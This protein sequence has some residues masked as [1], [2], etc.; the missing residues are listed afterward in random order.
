MRATGVGVVALGVGMWAGLGPAPARAEEPVASSLSGVAEVR[1]EEAAP[2]FPA[3]VRSL[4]VVR[5]AWAQLKP[6]LW[7]RRIGQIAKG[8]RIAWKAATDRL[9]K[10]PEG[11]CPRWIAVDPKGWICET[12]VEPSELEP[13]ATHLPV[14][15]DGYL[16]PER[17][18][19]VLPTPENPSRGGR[20]SNFEGIWAEGDTGLA[21]P[22]AWAQGRG[23]RGRI[24]PVPVRAAP[25]PDAEVV[26]ALTQ[27]TIVTPT[28]YSADKRFARV[29]E[30]AWVAV[31]DLHI[32][33]WTAPPPEVKP[34]E[35]WI[36]VDLDQQVLVA[37]EGTRPIAATL[38][39]SGLPN[40]QTP[41][42][43]FR[44]KWKHAVTRMAGT[45]YR[46]QVPWT[47]YYADMYALH[48]AYW[49]DRFGQHT[50]HGC[51]NVAPRD[52]R[53]LFAW[54]DPVLPPGWTVTYGVDEDPGSLVRVR[55]TKGRTPPLDAAALS[56]S[57]RAP[58][59][60]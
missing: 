43:K 47:M 59:S 27:R 21:L 37:Y 56:A 1:V 6:G 28:A 35:R 7:K 39:A 5:D 58:S 40:H 53:K 23:E 19:E 38:I 20:I 10:V 9:A 8:T 32:A 16:L 17:Y 42:G 29:G 26:R 3:H 49:H 25:S 60:P 12:D 36:D 15:R 51:I 14:I 4:R 30:G 57:G 22:L 13:S 52:A 44:V 41:V 33:A 11:Q 55:R 31:A 50:S 18:G 34:G 46:A 45:G 54:S 2:V 24:M 48:A